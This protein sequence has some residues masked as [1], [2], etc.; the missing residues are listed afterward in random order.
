[1]MIPTRSRS[2]LPGHLSYPIG[3]EVI[4]EALHGM[5]HV[6]SMTVAFRKQAVWPG[7]EFRRL[8]SA[9]LPYTILTGKYQPAHKPGL[10]GSDHMVQAGWYDEAW[11]LEVYPVH[12]EL[13]PVAARLLRDV[14]S[15]AIATWLKSSAKP[16]WAM[17]W[18]QI[19][20]V[21]SPADASLDLRESCGA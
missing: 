9:R 20:L 3:A 1:M 8:L 5:P 6:E 2:K 4:S 7:S 10:T 11:S 17:S 14:G 18:R 19:E 15:P 21:F 12:V 13:R 16:G